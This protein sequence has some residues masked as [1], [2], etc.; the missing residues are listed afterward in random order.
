MYMQTIVALDFTHLTV[1]VPGIL[2]T[3]E[4]LY[5][6][7]TVHSVIILS[8]LSQGWPP[9]VTWVQRSGPPRHCSPTTIA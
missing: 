6:S 5:T 2:L 7:L 8:P 1:F 4:V 9:S 3:L